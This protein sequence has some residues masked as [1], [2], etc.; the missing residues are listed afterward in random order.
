MPV[1]C[2][3]IIAYLLIPVVN[4][5]ERKIYHLLEENVIYL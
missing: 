2:G 1:I 3:A 4:F 5:Q